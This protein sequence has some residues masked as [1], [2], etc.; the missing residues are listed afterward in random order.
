MVKPKLND[1][2][3]ATSFEKILAG[4]DKAIAKKDAALAASS[5]AAE[6]NE[7]DKLEVHFA[8]Q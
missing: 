6:L 3:L 7:V 8:A 4:W 5:V 2:A 1:A